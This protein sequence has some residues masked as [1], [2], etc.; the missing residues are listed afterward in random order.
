MRQRLEW[1]ESAGNHETIRFS[2]EFARFPHTVGS[3]TIAL[4][5]NLPKPRRDPAVSRALVTA[6]NLQFEV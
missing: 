6:T 2:R 4:N 3:R 1:L 5:A